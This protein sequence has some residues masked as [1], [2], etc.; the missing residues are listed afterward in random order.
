MRYAYVLMAVGLCATLLNPSWATNTPDDGLCSDSVCQGE[1]K[2]LLKY[3]Q[4]GSPD[5]Q[6]IVAGMFAT[7]EGFSRDDKRARRYL[8]F[9]VRNGHPAAWYTYAVWLREGIA[10][11]PDSAKAQQVLE[12][13]AERL[14]YPQAQYEL[15][16]QRLDDS[17]KDNQAAAELLE[18]AAAENHMASRYLLAQLLA[19]G[20]GIP[21][22]HE[23]A[24]ELFY[25]LAQR[26]YKQSARRY[27]LL[28][29]EIETRAGTAAVAA[30]TERLEAPRNGDVE[31]IEVV[32]QRMPFEQM[33]SNMVEIIE[34]T[35]LYSGG[36]TGT[37]ISGQVCGQG[38]SQCSVIYRRGAD[39]KRNTGFT[40][41]DALQRSAFSQF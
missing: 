18:Q 30:I 39:D 31:V 23:R 9:A 33:L 13:A 36:S 16:L 29:D 17:G 27:Q 25:P 34:Q 4:A 28:L 19:A 7:G 5:A 15:A 14:K 2:Q 6:L 41:L 35:S 1:L 20:Y 22:D 12:R 38:T 26:D 21:A 32:G 10:F 3:A 37:G 24:V 11:A 40:V 8:N